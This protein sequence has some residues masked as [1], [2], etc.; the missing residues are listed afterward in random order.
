MTPPVSHPLSTCG[1]VASRFSPEGIPRASRPGARR[2]SAP[3]A[4][5][6][7][8][9]EPRPAPQHPHMASTLPERFDIAIIGAGF[10]GSMLAVHLAAAPEPPRVVLIERSLLFGPGLAYG[11]AS[12]EH[13]L[14]VPA[15]QMSAFPN[16]PLDFLHWVQTHP[17]DAREFRVTQPTP[18]AFLPRGL[19]GRYLASL[20]RHASYKTHRLRL[21][22]GEAIDI[23]PHGDDGFTVHLDNQ[24]PIQATQVV[25]AWGNFPPA[26]IPLS[27]GAI[28][29][30]PWSPEARRALEQPGEVLI[31]GTGLTCLDLL[32][33]AVKVGRSGPVHVL[34]RHG[35]FPQL[36]RALPPRPL[37]FLGDPLPTSIRSLFRLMR[38]ELRLAEAEG[39]DWRAVIDALRPFTPLIW[40]ALPAKER[41]RFLRHVRPLWEV[42]RHRAAPAMRQPIELLEARHQLIRHRGRLLNLSQHEDAIQVAFRP[43]GSNETRTLRVA[44]VINATGPEG[45]PRRIPAPLLKNLL[46]R[47]LLQPDPLGLGVRLTEEPSCGRRSLHLLGSLRRGSLWETT[48]VPELRVQAYETAQ[49]LLRGH[50]SNAVS[51]PAVIPSSPSPSLYP[52]HPWPFDI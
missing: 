7:F 31:L 45:D 6:Q 47:G 34:S 13:L 26:E 51:T 46:L 25:L 8:W 41:R 29:H 44:A 14:N 50:F 48:A 52:V 23:K 11:A 16:R 35:R 43:H 40:S 30:N 10:S 22:Q 32:A 36:H 12:Q 4:W 42:A 15:G 9:G 19:Y 21:L 38:D 27:Q 3:E 28:L 2:W 5:T 24:S 39:S 37:H 18:E 20:L 49:F 33:S 1:G 17:S